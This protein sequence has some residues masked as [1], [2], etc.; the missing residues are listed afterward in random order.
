[1]SDDMY[2]DI[3]KRCGAIQEAAI[4]GSTAMPYFMSH[5]ATFPYWTNRLG[6]AST[7]WDSDQM[8]NET[9]TVLMRLVIGHVT[10]GYDGQNE[11]LL[12]DYIDAVY[13]AFADINALRLIDGTTYT[14]EPT[15]LHPLG[16][17]IESDTGLD[18]FPAPWAGY[19]EVGVEFTLTV[20][21]Y[22]TVDD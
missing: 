3:K 9:R 7:D 21:V 12:G 13:D 19:Y 6:P 22:R 10:S 11:D 8:N 1:M 15:Y 5:G 4:S 18:L 17:E 20:N 14:T 16:V 2:T